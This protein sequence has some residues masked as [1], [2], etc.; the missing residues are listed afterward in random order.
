MYSQS[1]QIQ[2][3]SFI[4]CFFGWIFYICKLKIGFYSMKKGLVLEGGGMRGLFTAGIMDEMMENGIQP[5]GVVGVSAGATFGC[6]YKSNQP[7]RVLRYNIRFKDDP[8]YMGL[9]SLIQTGDLVNGPFSYHYMPKEL[10]VFDKETFA[11]SP[12][13]FHIVCTDVDTGKAVYRRLEKFEYEEIEWLRASA[14]LPCLSKPVCIGGY[15]LLDGGMADSIPL[16]YFQSQGYDRNIVVLTQPKGFK[17]TQPKIMPILKFLLRKTPKVAEA[18][19]VRHIMYNRELDYISEQEQLGNTLLIYPEDELPIGRT[20][21][22]ETKMRHVYAMGRE[23]A[24]QK[25]DEIK[26]FYAI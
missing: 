8:R 21:Q 14:S 1:V 25:M 5:D 13:D 24:K 15:R 4:F 26:A 6:N 17:K 3:T 12:I 16:Q 2:D 10:D 19:A 23:A 18:M 22:N 11:A 9:K 7:G 20:E